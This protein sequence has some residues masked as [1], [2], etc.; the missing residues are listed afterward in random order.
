MV[1]LINS[2]IISATD[3]LFNCFES[4]HTFMSADSF[5]HGIE[6]EM[7]KCPKGR[8]HDFPDFAE[9]VRKSNGG[10][11][12]IAEMKNED[13]KDFKS[14]H[15]VHQLKKS[16]TLLKDVFAVK[17]VRGSHK[18]HIKKSH[19]AQDFHEINFL[20]KTF[21]CQMP[22]QLRDANRGV[23][24]S[25]KTEILQKLCPLMPE[26][27]RRFWEDISVGEHNDDGEI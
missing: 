9:V 5:H 20:K 10:R 23:S 11:V 1:I 25:M 16:N 4:G 13:F 24:Q 19:D 17:F 14:A 22:G 3:I 8:V 12:D 21:R 15:S 18:L 2:D 7:K 26:T 27:R 6:L